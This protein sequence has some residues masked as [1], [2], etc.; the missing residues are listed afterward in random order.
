MDFAHKGFFLIGV[1]LLLFQAFPVAA[2]NLTPRPT[3]INAGSAATPRPTARASSFKYPVRQFNDAKL[4]V[5]TSTKFLFSNSGDERYKKNRS[6]YVWSSDHAKLIDTGMDG[7]ASSI[8]APD[9]GRYML[10]LYDDGDPAL[11]INGDRIT[12][13]KILRFYHF[14][15]RHAY[16]LGV[17]ARSATPYPDLIDQYQY[18]LKNHIVTFPV[19]EDGFNNSTAEINPSWYVINLLDIIYDIEG[20]PTPTPSFTPYVGGP[21]PTPTP[22]ATLPPAIK[23]RSDINNDG[24]IDVQDLLIFQQDWRTVRALIE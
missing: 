22:A 12:S 19:D 18:R 7:M 8:L 13:Q 21:S 9:D 11:D 14:D 10:F 16:N 20:T 2:Q 15:S 5:Q 1:S 6:L 4:E 3:I 23:A 24:Y 17:P